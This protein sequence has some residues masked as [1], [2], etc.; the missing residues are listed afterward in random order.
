MRINTKSPAR[1]ESQKLTPWATKEDNKENM[2]LDLEALEL[3]P[4]SHSQM[5][6]EPNGTVITQENS[7]SWAC[8]KEQ[9][10]A[11]MVHTSRSLPKF[12]TKSKNVE[13]TNL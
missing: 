12:M 13:K 5:F 1:K 2:N 4:K 11:S 3:S 10:P 6:L 7:F 9:I 8:S